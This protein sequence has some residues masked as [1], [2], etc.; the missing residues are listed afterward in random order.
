MD[1]YRQLL[2]NCS[3]NL[4]RLMASSFSSVSPPLVSCELFKGTSL[5]LSLH[6]NR[7]N[8]K[9]ASEGTGSHGPCP[10]SQGK[11]RFQRRQ[12]C[13]TE[14]RLLVKKPGGAV[15]EHWARSPSPLLLQRAQRRADGQLPHHRFQ[16]HKKDPS[17]APAPLTTLPVFHSGTSSS[18][19]L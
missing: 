12:L 19:Q 13:T 11:Q 10:V 17:H 8:R 5:S 4:K 9:T 15:Q 1:L 6:V 7:K 18:I 2:S 14:Q 3:R 16:N